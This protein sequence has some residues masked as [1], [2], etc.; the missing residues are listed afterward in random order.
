MSHRTV[1]LLVAILH[2]TCGL[3][4][5]QPFQEPAPVLRSLQRLA[6]ERPTALT[7]QFLAKQGI[8]TESPDR[9]SADRAKRA[10]MQAFEPGMYKISDAEM[11]RRQRDWPG[12]KCT[13]WYRRIYIGSGSFSDIPVSPPGKIVVPLREIKSSPS[14]VT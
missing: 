7:K 8:P 4:N 13:G 2:A 11:R 5:A 12:M 10:Y 6:A 14:C 1:S 9:L 3:I